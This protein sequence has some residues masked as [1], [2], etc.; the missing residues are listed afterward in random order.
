[1][2]PD[3]LRRRLRIRIIPGSIRVLLTIHQNRVI[4]RHT[5]PW[6]VGTGGTWSQ[7]RPVY[8]LFREIYISLDRLD[9]I[10]LRDRLSIPN[11]FCHVRPS[12]RFSQIQ[13]QDTPRKPE[14][15]EASMPRL[16]PRAASFIPQTYW[17]WEV[18]LR[19]PPELHISRYATRSLKPQPPPPAS[20]SPD[21]VSCALPAHPSASAGLSS[22]QSCS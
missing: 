13:W 9:F 19:I 20:S 8:S 15:E 10:A 18:A 21:Q 5:L 12:N 1:M 7:K 11:C 3:R 4:P 22:S 14:D 16:E 17:K 6:A 2:M